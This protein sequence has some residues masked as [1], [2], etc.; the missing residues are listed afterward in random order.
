[1]APSTGFVLWFTG[2]SGAGKSTLAAHIAPLLES[3]GKNVEVLD[4]DEIRAHLSQGLGFTKDDRDMNV[5]RIGFVATL[6]ARNECA[7]ITAAISPYAAIRAECRQRT[8]GSGARFVEIWVN[9][10]LEVV[11]KRDTKGLYAKARAGLIKHFTGVSDPYEAPEAPEVTV[12]TGE[13]TVEESIAKILAFL[14]SE[15]L[16]RPETVTS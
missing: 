12:C 13:E 2:L 4:G 6:L 10:P 15:G 5:R 7:A 8:E 16:V 9:A 3:R 14:E 11:E 1:M